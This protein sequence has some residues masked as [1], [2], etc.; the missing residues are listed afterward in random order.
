MCTSVSI[1]I[2]ELMIRCDYL[3]RAHPSFPP[4]ISI[5]VSEE[6]TNKDSLRVL[7]MFLAFQCQRPARC[8]ATSSLI[9][10]FLATP[11]FL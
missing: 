9:F 2:Y 3:W 8:G 6:G 10:S 5:Y 7:V 11:Y 1:C 4:P